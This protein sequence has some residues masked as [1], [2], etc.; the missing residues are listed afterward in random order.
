VAEA[1][2]LMEEEA[3]EQGLLIQAEQ[4]AE[5]VLIE[6]FGYAGYEA[7]IQFDGE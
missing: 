6:F 7:T 3:L 5:R 2:E 1:Q 4:N